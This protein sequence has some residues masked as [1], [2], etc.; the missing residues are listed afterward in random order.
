MSLSSNSEQR[1]IFPEKS[2]KKKDK[3]VYN[4]TNF[5]S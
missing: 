1:I 4:E 5:S 3:G 2:Y